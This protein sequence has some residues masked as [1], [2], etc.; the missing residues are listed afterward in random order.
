ML[1]EEFLDGQEV[2]LFLLSD[3]THVLPL[4]PRAGLQAPR[5]TATQGPNTGGMGAYSPLPWLDGRFGSERRSSTRSSTRS[6]CPPCAS[7]RPSRPRSSGCSTRASSSP[8]RGIRVIEFNA[9]FGDPETQVVLPRLVDAAVG[10]AVRRRDRRARRAAATRVLDRCRRHRRARE[11]GLPEAPDTG[12]VDRGARRRGIRAGCAHRPRRHRDRPRRRRVVPRSS[13]PA[14]ACSASSRSD[15][16]FAEARRRAYEALGHI[17]L[18]GGAVPHRHRRARR[19][20]TPRRTSTMR[21]TATASCRLDAR[22]LGQGARPLR[23]GDARRRRHVDRRPA[24]RSRVVLVVASDRV[25]AFDHVLEP[26]HPRQGRD[27]HAAQPV[28][29]RRSSPRCRTTWRTPRTTGSSAAPIPAEVADRAMLVPH[30]RHVPDRVRRARL[31]HRRRLEGVP[32]DAAPSCGIPLPAG[33]AER[34]PA[35]RAD[36]H[37]GV[38]GAAGRARREHLVRAHRRAGRARPSPSSCATSRSRSSRTRRRSPRRAASSSPTRSSSSAPTATTGIVT[39][40]DEVLTS[41]SSRYWDAEAYAPAATPELAWRASTSRSCATGSPRT[42]TRTRG[43]AA[44]RCPHEIVEQTAARYRE[45]ID[46][47]TTGA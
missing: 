8:T 46:R 5:A 13:P 19:G 45:L 35:A 20:V 43:D 12:R 31:P 30:A 28:V 11:R 29:V 14:A 37:A 17:R 36:L 34:R 15:A 18:E 47:L 21:P 39:L 10:P 22:L 41:D 33:L 6:R 26:A 42:G 4:S 44:R 40:A 23:A 24:R 7:S 3:G 1:V 32:G 38:E 25:S 2:S 16:D 27:A 9:R